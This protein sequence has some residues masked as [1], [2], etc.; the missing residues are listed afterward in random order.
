MKTLKTSILLSL[1]L[2][3]SV[4]ANEKVE[5][6][7]TI[8]SKNQKHD[9]ILFPIPQGVATT[10]E[11]LENNLTIRQSTNLDEMIMVDY[12]DMAQTKNR[13]FYINCNTKQQKR[14]AKMAM[15]YLDD[16][17][18]WRWQEVMLALH[19]NAEVFY[20]PAK[21]VNYGGS[22]C[23]EYLGTPCAQATGVFKGRT[24]FLG[25]IHAFRNGNID[26][27][28]RLWVKSVQCINDHFVSAGIVL[29]GTGVYRMPF[30]PALEK[31]GRVLRKAP[32]HEDSL[33]TFI[34]KDQL[35]YKQMANVT[36]VDKMR[37]EF[38]NPRS[39]VPE[40]EALQNGGSYFLD[41]AKLENRMRFD[42]NIIRKLNR[43]LRAQGL[44]VEKFFTKDY[45][46]K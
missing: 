35:I 22:E 25:I 30:N 37:E 44:P 33:Y 40:E 21:G 24:G 17:T 19:P 3:S 28:Y 5:E 7:K 42:N 13:P 36:F 14:N 16:I 9:E 2:S 12:N 32:Y 15:K 10:T 20:E 8:F 43:K 18:E 31:P 6:L 1:L 23:S 4:M 41:E 26:S 29:A 46:Q 11:G 34:F 38:R 27:D 39:V 45:Y